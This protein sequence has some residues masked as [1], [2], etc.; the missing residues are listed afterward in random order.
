VRGLV[1]SLPTLRAHGWDIRALCNE[2]QKTQPP[3]EATRLP[4]LS[5]LVF[6]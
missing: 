5:V 2:V 3:V 6:S 4:K 1:E